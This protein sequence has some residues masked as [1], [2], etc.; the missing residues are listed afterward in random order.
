M[1]L[2][3]ILCL[4]AVVH[5]AMGQESEELIQEQPDQ[6]STIIHVDYPAWSVATA[7]DIT[8][9]TTGHLSGSV[10]LG[11]LP[12]VGSSAFVVEVVLSN[13]TYAVASFGTASIPGVAGTQNAFVFF[14]PVNRTILGTGIASIQGSSVNLDITNS[15]ISGTEVVRV[16]TRYAPND[17]IVEHGTEVLGE[18]SASLIRSDTGYRTVDVDTVFT[19]IIL[20]L[21]EPEGPRCPPRTA[22]DWAWV[23]GLSDVNGDGIPDWDYIWDV[24]LG[25]SDVLVDLRGV[26]KS[27]AGPSINDEF[28]L[29]IGHDSNQN[30]RLEDS[31]ITQQIGRCQYVNGDNDLDMNHCL[32]A[33]MRFTG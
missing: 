8:V 26:D 3:A 31:E 25:G 16:K 2:F 33:D 10:S 1:K 21:D 19:G 17:L 6:S 20:P 14:D 27:P 18:L 12:M 11:A 23:Q 29:V 22:Q 13:N 4:V 5:L 32:A 24:R 30:G 15:V 7:H 9:S 28:I